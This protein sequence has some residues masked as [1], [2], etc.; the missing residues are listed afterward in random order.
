MQQEEPILQLPDHMDEATKQQL[1]EKFRLAREEAALR[2]KEGQHRW[3]TSL[4]QQLPDG[5]TLEDIHT[6]EPGKCVE[7]WSGGMRFVKCIAEAAEKGSIHPYTKAKY[8]SQQE[9]QE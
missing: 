1:T 6:P 9:E 4:P 2:V 7:F 5:T 3:A 8:A